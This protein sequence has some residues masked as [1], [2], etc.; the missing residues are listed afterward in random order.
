MR[1]AVIF[2]YTSEEEKNDQYNLVTKYVNSINKE[3]DYDSFDSS[4]LIKEIV[5]KSLN[6]YY[7]VIIVPSIF[8]LKENALYLLKLID[9][10]QAIDS[11]FI[12]VK[13]GLL[14][15]FYES[16]SALF[17]VSLLSSFN[18]HN[19]SESIKSGMRKAIRNPG[20][21]LSPKLQKAKT[22][23]MEGQL[24]YREI[25]RQTGVSKSSLNRLRERLGMK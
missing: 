6:G 19:N 5:Q 1:A 23:L 13:E 15:D 9:E 21:P 22:L 17:A 2:D 16:K 3:F 20:R 7:D 18:N 11:K 4:A 12:A 24:S 8:I 14:D 10:L 25:M